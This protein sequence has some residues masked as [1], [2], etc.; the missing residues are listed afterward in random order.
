MNNK[1][2]EIAMTWLITTL[3]F[4]SNIFNTYLTVTISKHQML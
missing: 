3:L 4:S 1:Y 2:Y